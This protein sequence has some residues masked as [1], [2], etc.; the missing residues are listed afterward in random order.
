MKKINLIFI[1]ILFA[2]FM[3]CSDNSTGPGEADTDL[4]RGTSS[5]NVTGDIEANHD[6]VA[7]YVGLRSEGGNFL[8]LSLTVSDSELGDEEDND[9]NLTFRFVGNEGPFELETREYPIGAE[10]NVVVF[11]SYSNSVVSDETLFYAASPNA[12]GS[13]RILSFSDTSIEAS[14]N[15]TIE[16]GRNR[17]G[18]PVTISGEINAECLTA[19]I[20]FGC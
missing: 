3:S 11:S 2:G 12:T 15:F 1:S 13:I 17:E 10:N 7:W 9:F 18:D 6:G 14:F 20:N 8:N 5:F 4:S 19:E 16:P